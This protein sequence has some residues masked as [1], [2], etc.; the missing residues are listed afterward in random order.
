MKR[1]KSFKL[2][3]SKFDVSQIKSI[4]EEDCKKFLDEVGG[5]KFYR[6]FRQ[7]ERYEV[8]PGLYHIYNTKARSPKDTKIEVSDL[9]DD[10]FEKK[11]GVRPR[12]DAVFTTKDERI[13]G[14][15]GK[16]FLFYPIGDY[17][18]LYNPDI[19]DLYHELQDL[20][21]Y[22]DDIYWWMHYGDESGNGVWSILDYDFTDDYRES[23]RMAKEIRPELRKD[24]E[25]LIRWKPEVSYK[26]WKNE[27]E[28]DKMDDIKHI[29]SGYRETGLRDLSVRK[30]PE[31][32]FLCDEYYL[33]DPNINIYPNEIPKDI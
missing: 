14:D 3:E 9:L 13:P 31:I 5:A 19:V 22:L 12:K 25:N 7:A 11:F 4:I 2:F 28:E 27:Q 29:V 8:M 20:P 33:V 10:H 16:T 30:S 24:I 15:Y 18:Y 26:E 1:L 32:M 21:W 17:R 23:V 6:G